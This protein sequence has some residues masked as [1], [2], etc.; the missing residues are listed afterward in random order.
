MIEVTTIAMNRC[1]LSERG[2]GAF[3]VSKGSF[4]R[5]G[6][7]RNGFGLKALDGWWDEQLGSPA[8]FGGPHRGRC[9]LR[10]EL[11]EAGRYSR[12]ESPPDLAERLVA[13]RLFSHVRAVQKF[14][15]EATTL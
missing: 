15:P 11:A 8:G 2:F 4:R 13:W 3:I 9:R 12:G 5:Q 6:R 7:R 10:E 1:A 14:R